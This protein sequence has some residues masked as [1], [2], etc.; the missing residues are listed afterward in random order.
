MCK[1]NITNSIVHCNI[2]SS[3]INKR[4]IESSN[5]KVNIKELLIIVYVMLKRVLDVHNAILR[6]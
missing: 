3:V 6:V 2:M 5:Y 4:Y 1:Y